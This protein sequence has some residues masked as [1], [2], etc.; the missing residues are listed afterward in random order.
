[1]MKKIISISIM[2][3]LLISAMVVFA[4][5]EATYRQPKNKLPQRKVGTEN[6][7]DK[8]DELRSEVKTY[9]NQVKENKVKQR[10][11]LTQSKESYREAKGHV[12]HLL[13]NKDSLTD[14][15]VL[16]LKESLEV[17]RDRDVNFKNTNGNITKMTE[18]LRDA[19]E[20]KDYKRAKNIYLKII[21]VQNS[22]IEN[23]TQLIDNLN[24]INDI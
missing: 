1:M 8:R 20:K 7:T 4:E 22:R 14:D 23:M 19:R 18:Q 5:D 3:C 6:R 17:L 2:I 24:A 21:E 10:E 13:E 15:Q 12:R 16:K 11:L 9:I